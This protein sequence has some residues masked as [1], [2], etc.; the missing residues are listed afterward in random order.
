[1]QIVQWFKRFKGIEN[2]PHFGRLSTLK[3]NENI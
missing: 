1:M 3:T 2:D